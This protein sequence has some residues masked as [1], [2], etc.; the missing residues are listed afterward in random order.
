MLKPFG[1]KIELLLKEALVFRLLLLQLKL[2]APKQLPR[3]EKHLKSS[4]RLWEKFSWKKILESN[5][6]HLT[7]NTDS[8]LPGIHLIVNMFRLNY[9]GRSNL[10]K[11][12]NRA[13]F[14]R[15]YSA[16]LTGLVHPVTSQGILS[17]AESLVWNLRCGMSNAFIANLHSCWLPLENLNSD[18]VILFGESR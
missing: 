3:L 6:F 4:S 10:D 8:V 9:D 5:S 11:A 17:N 15:K 13:M 7:L 2:I 18:S 14:D 12:W 16:C 1:F